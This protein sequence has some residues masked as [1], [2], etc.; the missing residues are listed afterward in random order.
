MVFAGTVETIGAILLLI[1]A[2]ATVGA[3]ICLGALTAV[4]TQSGFYLVPD[5]VGRAAPAFPCLFSCS[6]RGTPPVERPRSEPG[7]GAEA[8][9]TAPPASLAESLG[10]GT[11]MRASLYVIVHLSVDGVGQLRLRNTIPQTSPLYG[12]WRVENATADGAPIPSLPSSTIPRWQRITVDSYGLIY[13]KMIVASQ[14]MDGAFSSAYVATA[15]TKD[16]TVSIRSPSV[17]AE[18]YWSEG[19]TGERSPQLKYD[20]LSPDAMVLGRPM[21]GHQV[22]LTLRKED[23]HFALRPN[24]FHWI[25]EYNQTGWEP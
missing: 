18:K 4:V 21:N 6:A 10:L 22:R 12:I 20:R 19:L 1:P 23:R 3:L 8:E 2:T 16:S 5:K 24:R 7:D 13:P 11:P 14:N 15:N 25:I 9:T 17:W